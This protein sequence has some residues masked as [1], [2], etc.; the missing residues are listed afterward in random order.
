MPTGLKISNEKRISQGKC[1][2]TSKLNHPHQG[3][4]N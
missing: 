3:L 2:T 1:N 4:E